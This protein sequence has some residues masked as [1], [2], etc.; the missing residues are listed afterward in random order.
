M[1]AGPMLML[2]G[3]SLAACALAEP[4]PLPEQTWRMRPLPAQ[5][6]GRHEFRLRRLEKAISEGKLT[7]EEA[8]LA[9]PL[10]RRT[11]TACA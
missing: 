2:A 1:L 10:A 9:P 11:T 4:P 8:D 7:P 6:E 3:M 5:E